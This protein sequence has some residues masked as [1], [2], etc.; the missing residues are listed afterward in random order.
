MLDE[1][2]NHIEENE[3]IAPGGQVLLAVSG[4][5]DSVVMFDLMVRAGYSCAIAHCNFRLR[6]DESDGDEAFVRKL[7][8][9]HGLPVF[10]R[11]FET[12]AI[13]R[14]R[15]IS[16]QMAARE[17]RYEWFDE[18]RSDRKYDL[19]ATAH[20]LDDLIETFF[21]NLIRGTGIRGLSGIRP[22]TGSLIRPMLFAPRSDIA[23]YAADRHLTFREDS[24]NNS[25]KYL[26]NRIRHRI[27]PQL[28]EI[29]PGF[30]QGIISTIMKLRNTEIIYEREIE[31]SRKTAGRFE[32]GHLLLSIE[33]LKKLDERATFLYEFISPFNFSQ[34][35]VS[36]IEKSLDGPSGK[37]FFSDTHRL[38]KDREHLI[39]SPL[40]ENE[41]TRYYIDD[42]IPGITEPVKMDLMS[43]NRSAHFLIPADPDTACLDYDKLI[44]PLILRKWHPGDHFY[45][46][47]MPHSKKISDYFIDIK[48]SIVDKEGTWLLLSGEN[49][50]WVVGHR[51]DD[52]YKVTK[53]TRQIY[54]ARLG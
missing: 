26:R 39:I 31:S 8:G 5:V 45:P 34:K 10:T 3:L 28:Q 41:I 42:G 1:L 47:G 29:N 35:A 18:I 25:T 4:G 7:G 43:I 37:Q 52:R 30:K 2:R 36:D 9:D 51:I 17:L 19:V 23:A 46:L 21:I 20:N 49:I 13:A 12:V 32:G 11:S 16:V 50:V 15:R 24:S 38:L 54:I 6:G 27:I 53:A 44:F 14:E 48:L 22:R 40:S 33:K